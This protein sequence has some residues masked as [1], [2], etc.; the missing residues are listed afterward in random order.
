[1]TILKLS[2]S[3]HGTKPLILNQP[4]FQEFLQLIFTRFSVYMSASI[5]CFLSLASGP[6]QQVNVPRITTVWYN[7]CLG[8]GAWFLP[9]LTPYR[10]WV[11][12]RA[13]IPSPF[14]ANCPLPALSLLVSTVSA[15]SR[16]QRH[17]AVG[18][19]YIYFFFLHIFLHTDLHL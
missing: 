15:W 7:R 10:L 13:L 1:M 17:M 19:L 11:A 4:H 14:Q 6:Q 18:R 12:A 2:R 9:S 3:G 16:Q 8:P 5:L